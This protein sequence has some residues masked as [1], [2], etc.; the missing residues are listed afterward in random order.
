[1]LYSTYFK[2]LV[3]EEDRP[4]SIVFLLKISIIFVQN[5]DLTLL[6]I[7]IVHN[8]FSLRLENITF[9]REQNGPK[10]GADGFLFFACLASYKTPH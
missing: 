1:M 9:E 10:I 8:V 4:A 6:E 3:A 2:Y 7:F 5:I